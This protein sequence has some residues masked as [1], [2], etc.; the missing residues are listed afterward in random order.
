MRF[1]GGGN[2]AVKTPAHLFDQMIAFYRDALGLA[3]EQRRDDSW[4]FRFGALKLWVDRV[5]ALSQPEVWLEVQA[6]D[7]ASAAAADLKAHGVTRCDD[8]EA[9]P[10]GFA[11]FWIAAPGGVVHLVTAGD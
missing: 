1:S 11:G 10:D 4:A 7:D 5:A 9:L 2:I 8:V 6:T 3:V